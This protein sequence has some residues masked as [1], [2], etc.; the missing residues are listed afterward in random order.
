MRLKSSAYSAG[1][2]AGRA[3]PNLMVVNG[4]KYLITPRCPFT[5]RHFISLFLWHE[6]Y[7]HGTMQRLTTVKG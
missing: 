6:G 3:E 2:R 7:Y 1:K 5:L 4:L